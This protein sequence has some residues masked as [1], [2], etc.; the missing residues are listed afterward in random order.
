MTDESDTQFAAH[1]GHVAGVIGTGRTHVVVHVM[2]GHDESV[3][4]GEEEQTERIR[5]A[6][7]GEVDGILGRRE[8]TRIK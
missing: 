1:R 8:V 7:D 6:R 4:E 5:A 3:L 2:D